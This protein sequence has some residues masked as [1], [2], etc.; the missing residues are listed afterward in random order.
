MSPKTPR[1]AQEILRS[2]SAGAHPTCLMCGSSNSRGLHLAFEVCG[3]GKV[4]AS[5]VAED[6][7]TGYPNLLHGG[8]VASLLDA[9]ITNCLFA[10]GY[11]AV[12]AELNVRYRHPVLIQCPI[13]VHGRLDRTF[14]SLYYLR[15]EL[16]QEGVVKAFASAKFMSTALGG[17]QPPV[18]HGHS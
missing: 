8:M 12:T 9:A 16:L 5:F 6:V 14:H 2:T 13:R 4:E 10:H 3:D 11:V 15:A 18:A 7:L 17:L 1:P